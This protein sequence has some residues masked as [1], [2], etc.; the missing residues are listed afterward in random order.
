MHVGSAVV[1]RTVAA[2]LALVAWGA[3]LLQYVLVLASTRASGGHVV[4]ATASYFGDFTVLAILCVAL[5]LAAE[6]VIPSV[7]LW[8]FLA[9]PSARGA[10][11]AYVAVVAVVYAAALRVAARP[12]GLFLLADLLLH[13]VMPV[14]YLGFWLVRPHES[15]LRWRDAAVWLVLPGAYLAWVLLH[16]AAVGRYPYPFLDARA[17]GY[18]ATAAN[19]T[20]L[21]AACWAA[22]MAVVGADRWRGE[23]REPVSAAP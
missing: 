7:G 8:N 9:R 20:L 5:T 22:G 17:L 19:A 12:R 21:M 4:D 11:A 13:D 14:A 10:I 1:R 15:R 3:L 16:G 2:V 18:A 23:G 6:L